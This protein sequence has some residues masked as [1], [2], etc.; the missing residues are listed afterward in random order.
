MIKDANHYTWD[1]DARTISPVAV[2]QRWKHRT[3]DASG[4]IEHVA[5]S[6]TPV[7]GRFTGTLG[8]PMVVRLKKDQDD[9]NPLSSNFTWDHVEHFYKHME[10]VE[11]G[12]VPEKIDLSRFPHKCPR[13]SKPAYVG[14]VMAAVDCT[15]PLCLTKKI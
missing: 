1:A 5:F 12:P 13:C 9:Y 15:N 3:L 7:H 2:G 10:F 14:A 11:W 6:P 8:C 4:V